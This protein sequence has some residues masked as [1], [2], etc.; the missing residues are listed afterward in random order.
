M[1]QLKCNQ[2]STNNVCRTLN[3]ELKITK[4]KLKNHR[5]K[6]KQQYCKEYIKKN[7]NKKVFVPEQTNKTKFKMQ[8][9]FMLRSKQRSERGVK[10]KKVPSN[11][12]TRE[13]LPFP[14]YPPRSWVKCFS[15]PNKTFFFD[16]NSSYAMLLLIKIRKTDGIVIV[17]KKNL[18][19]S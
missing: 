18:Q 16:Q 12:A 6:F 2:K 3:L 15:F 7:Q 14:K 1:E 17:L 11:C 9:A 4:Q 19:F 8:A 10:S 13:L 5:K